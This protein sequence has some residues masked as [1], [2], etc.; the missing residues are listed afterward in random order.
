MVSLDINK[1]IR[2]ADSLEHDPEGHLLE[3]PLWT[4]TI[5]RQRA[6]EEGIELSGAH[7]EVLKFLRR[8]YAEHGPAESGR[9][10]AAALEQ[11]F[12][13]EGGRRWLYTL[14]PHG[15]VLQG[16]HI[17]GLPV[18]PHTTDPAFGSVE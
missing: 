14:F 2:N 13:E 17:A 10:V 15:P 16:C 1:F 5:A 11:A 8:H 3:L 4:E 12:A 9:V 7:W 18:P 6:E